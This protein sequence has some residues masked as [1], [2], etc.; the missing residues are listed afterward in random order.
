MKRKAVCCLH[1]APA[2]FC[3]ELF[4]GCW[5]MCF[6]ALFSTILLLYIALCTTT[7]QKTDHRNDIVNFFW[8]Y[9]CTISNISVA[10]WPWPLFWIFLV[11]LQLLV[12]FVPSNVKFTFVILKWWQ[13]SCTWTLYWADYSGFSI[14]YEFQWFHLSV[15]LHCDVPW[16]LRIYISNKYSSFYAPI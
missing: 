5:Y 10:K 11:P 16:I 4:P 15:N 2:E 6:V 9:T 14:T 13:Y 12:E 8:C 7:A 1:T 3:F